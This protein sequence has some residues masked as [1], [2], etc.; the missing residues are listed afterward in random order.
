M[1][2]EQRRITL[3]NKAGGLSVDEVNRDGVSRYRITTTCHG[4]AADALPVDG[5]GFME[6][7]EQSILTFALAIIEKVSKDD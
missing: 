2:S 3:R 5:L 7:S 4:E 1:Y 6:L